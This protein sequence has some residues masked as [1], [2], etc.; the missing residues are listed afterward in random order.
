MAALLLP[1]VGQAQNVDYSC[2]FEDMSDS[3]GWVLLNGTQTNQWY[4]GTDSSN[5]GSRALFVSSVD[6]SSNV[7]DNSIT[8]IT[9]AYREFELTPG[10]YY[11]S[12]N[13]HAYGEGSY[14]YLRVFLVPSSVAITAGL[15]PD[16]TT[17]TYNF[18]TAPA[19]WIP[20]DGNSRL[21]GESTWQ[22]YECEFSVSTADTY[23]LVFMWCND[24]SAGT[25]PPAAVDNIVL[26]QPTC[27]RPAMP[28]VMNLT[29]TSFD[30]YWSDMTDGNAAEWIVEIDSATQAHGMGTVY[31]SN[32]TSITF[33]GL[34]PNTTYTLWISAVCAGTDS[35]MELRYQVRTPCTYLT[36]LPYYQDF[37]TTTMGSSMSTTFVDCWNRQTTVPPILVIPMCRAAPP[38]RIMEERRAC[39]GTTHPRRVH[40]ALI[41][42]LPCRGWIP[43][44]CRCAM[45]S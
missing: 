17:S 25:N 23:R 5:V 29:T 3:A 42:V 8:S 35:S 28:Y 32:D 40:T 21:N 30:L 37:E 4:I 38:I 45:C 18:S 34:T 22:Y 36:T 12:Y 13:W 2:D 15:L 26:T 41:S 19:G 39:I 14:D 7:Y 1:L 6:S 24:P 9:Y 20:L 27:A 11:M 33:T 43:I 44:M 10:G 31:S 16:G